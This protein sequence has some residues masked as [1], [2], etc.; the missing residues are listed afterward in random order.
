MS[1]DPRRVVVKVQSMSRLVMIAVFAFSTGCA[2][3]AYP[4]CRSDDHCRSTEHCFDGT[5][6]QCLD[7]A[8]CGPGFLCFQGVCQ[9]DLDGCKANADC[10]AGKACILGLCSRCFEDDQCG[11]GRL[12][13]D[14]TCVA[15]QVEE[16]EVE[17]QPAPEV[18]GP[19]GCS[20]EPVYFD[21]DSDQLTE[22][23]KKILDAMLGC[24]D[25]ERVYSI[26]GR[27]DET[28]DPYYNLDLG[29]RRAEAV[30]S[31]LVSGGFPESRLVISSAGEKFASDDDEKSRRV[32]IE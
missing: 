3:L 19:D 6:L 12:C 21:W 10:E 32:D 15:P 26:I 9:A 8:G 25:P 1:L 23:A 30:K 11:K 27:A 24:L 5:C 14:A 16:M 18:V 17:A 4:S 13:M 7:D 28:G 29:L 20:I 2:E 22:A 31:H